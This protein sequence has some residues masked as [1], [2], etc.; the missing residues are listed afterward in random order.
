MW[1][2]NLAFTRMRPNSLIPYSYHDYLTAFGS[3]SCFIKMKTCLILG[4]LTLISIS[5]TIYLFGSADGGF[6][7]VLL[8]K[9]S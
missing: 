3:G 5:L 6:N 9:Y 8:L 1:G 2:P 4:L 7:L